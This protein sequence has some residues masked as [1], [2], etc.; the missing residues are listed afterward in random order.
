MYVSLT[1]PLSIVQHTSS[2]IVEHCK[3]ESSTTPDNIVWSTVTSCW[4]N[5]VCQFDLSLR[6]IWA[7]GFYWITLSACQGVGM[8]VMGQLCSGCPSWDVVD[9]LFKSSF[10]KL[11]GLGVPVW[12]S[13]LGVCQVIA[14]TVDVGG[15]GAFV[16]LGVFAVESSF[17]G[18]WGTER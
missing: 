10:E 17:G 6:I 11:F 2:Q 1:Y 4:A 9:L 15:G 7:A 5:N 3:L 14:L 16:D 18:S 13:D 12:L 8:K